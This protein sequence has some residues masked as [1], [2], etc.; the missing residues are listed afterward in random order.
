MLIKKLPIL[1]ISLQTSNKE[2]SNIILCSNMNISIQL[3]SPGLISL[4]D[5][6]IPLCLILHGELF[7]MKFIDQYFFEIYLKS[8]ICHSRYI[9]IF[10]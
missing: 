4:F 3:Y 5:S 10:K 2:L 9:I 6:Y 7:D 1:L 8:T